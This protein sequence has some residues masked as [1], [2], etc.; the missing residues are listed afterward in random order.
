MDE[1]TAQV[2]P[3]EL[4][5]KMMDAAISKGATLEIATVEV[6][7]TASSVGVVLFENAD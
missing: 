7:E 5:T 2:T 4:T 3:L 1:G 6:R